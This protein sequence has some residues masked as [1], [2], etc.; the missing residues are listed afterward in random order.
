MGVRTDDDISRHRQ[1]LLRQKRVFD[2]HLTHIKIIADPVLCGKFAHTFTVLRRFDVLIR[3]KVIHDKRDLIL[4]KYAVHLHLFD[5][6][7]RD[8]RCDVVA[9]HQIQIRHDQLSGMHFAQMRMCR[10]DLLGHCHSHCHYLLIVNI[11][12]KKCNIPLFFRKIVNVY[13]YHNKFL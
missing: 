4:M 2:P 11:S 10:K 1:T 7:D 9:E 12:V 5:L 3:D 8:R 6:F 13:I